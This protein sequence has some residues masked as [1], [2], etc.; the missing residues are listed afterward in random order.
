MVHLHAGQLWRQRC[1]FGLLA[2]FGVHLGRGRQHLE[3]LLNGGDVGIDRFIEQAGLG[4]IEL[5][6]AS[7]EL[8]ALESRHLVRELVDLGL[9]VEDFAVFADDGLCILANLGHQLRDHF[10]QLLCVQICQRIRCQNHA[11]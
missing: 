10:T 7:A 1:A 11:L 2:G 6:T 3:L 5:L 4:L 9:A 8:P